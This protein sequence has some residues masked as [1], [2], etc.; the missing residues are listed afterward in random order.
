MKG[1]GGEEMNYSNRFGEIKGAEAEV[2]YICHHR[3]I[4]LSFYPLWPSLRNL[5]LC[6]RHRH[7]HYY[8]RG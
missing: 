3:M 6:R 5:A 1:E 8:S 2:G 7:R 4:T